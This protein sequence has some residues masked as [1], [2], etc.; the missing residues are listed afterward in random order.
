LISTLYQCCGSIRLCGC[1]SAGAGAP[2]FLVLSYPG[3][4]PCAQ[5]WLD[6]AFLCLPIVDTQTHKDQSHGSIFPLHRVS[7]STELNPA[8]RFRLPLDSVSVLVFLY[9]RTRRIP[10]CIRLGT[11]PPATVTCKFHPPCRRCPARVQSR[12]LQSFSQW[13]SVSPSPFPDTRPHSRIYPPTRGVTAFPRAGC[14]REGQACLPVY[15][16]EVPPP[17]E[18]RTAVA[19][20]LIA[21]TKKK[22]LKRETADEFPHV[23][24]EQPISA[25]DS[26]V[27][28]QIRPCF[29]LPPLHPLPRLLL[30]RPDLRHCGDSPAQN[31]APPATV[32][33]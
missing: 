28:F 4:L 32:P 25:S 3:V 14:E 12:L 13:D 8:L 18:T 23:M 30:S 27:Y 7:P 5:G 22:V 11:A 20:N 9:C 10:R 2:R 19:E 26:I 15:T 17:F 1:S 31:Q 21:I 16:A 33:A 29:R 24:S 6:V